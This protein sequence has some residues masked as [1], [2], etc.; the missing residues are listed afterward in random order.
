MTP[1]RLTT[2]EHADLLFAQ[3]SGEA[4][5]RAW[6]VVAPLMIRR[7]LYAAI[8]DEMVRIREDVTGRQDQLPRQSEEN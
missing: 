2:D 5:R 6:D 8:G 7:A 3:L 4:C 1:K